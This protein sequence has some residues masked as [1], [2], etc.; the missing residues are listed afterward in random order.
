MLT[1]FTSRHHLFC[2]CEHKNDEE[3]EDEMKTTQAIPAHAD[4]QALTVMYFLWEAA[5]W[6]SVV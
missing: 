5:V 1:K 3:G 2:A 4:V 6:H